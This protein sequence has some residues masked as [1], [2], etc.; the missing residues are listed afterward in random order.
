VLAA[1]AVLVVAPLTGQGRVLLLDWVL[2][3][4]SPVVSPGFFGLDG[5]LNLGLAPSIAIGILAHVLG[6]VLNWLVLAMVFPVAG[7]SVARLVGRTLPERL[8]AAVIYSV[9]PFVVERLFAGQPLILLA[10]AI[11]PLAV[12]SLLGAVDRQGVRRL[13]PVLWLALLIAVAPQFSWIAGVPLV[14]VVVWR[15][16]S[17]K[18]LSWAGSILA[19][20]A[21]SCVYLIVPTLGHPSAVSLPTS[22]LADFATKAIPGTSLYLTTAGLYGFWRP[23]AYVTPDVAAGWP[24]LLVAIL[25][26]AAAGAYS[27]F[28]D[29]QRRP[30]AFVVLSSGA[31]GYF[32]AL[33]DQGPTGF[34][35]TWAYVHVPLFALMREAEIFAALVALAYAVCFAWGV[36]HLVGVARSRRGRL[37]SAALAVALPLAYTP[38]IFWGLGGKVTP[39][40]IPASWAA[41]NRLMG[42]GTGKVLFLPWHQYLAF[43]FTGGRV[44]ANPAPQ[45]FSRPT[46]AGDNVQFPNLET[47]STSPR[48]AFLDFLISEDHATT[49]LGALLA[50]LG[51]SY[52]VLSK[53]VDWRSYAWLDSQVDVTRILDT[54]T[55]EVWRNDVPAPLGRQVQALRRVANFSS[56]VALADQ[57]GFASTAFE[58][59]D[60]GPGPVTTPSPGLPPPGASPP[61]AGSVRR[62]SSVSY[63]ISAAPGS[64]VEVSSTY[65]LGWQDGHSKAIKLAEGNM[66]FQVSAPTTVARYTPW[67]WVLGGYIFSVLVLLAVGGLIFGARLRGASARA[68]GLAGYDR[69]A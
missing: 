68:P 46:I 61:R 2:G 57:P 5:G 8:G 59:T 24:F 9:N 69:D 21:A 15:R 66:A 16:F 67:S 50:P 34:L 54:P 48:G 42:S 4:K 36:G 38:T 44:I 41:A 33:G 63:S 62:A 51:V 11:L 7:L 37:A 55:L 12:G 18:V 32:L 23:A 58:V 1:V 30:L 64:Y 45:F 40:R 43:P 25:V 10:Y 28:R 27:A 22:M 31:A 60:P 14:A 20:L 65:Q 17:L 49:H 19:I 47:Q 35:F 56:L 39:S 26:V 3:P 13:T 52:V 53:T 29:P 6:P